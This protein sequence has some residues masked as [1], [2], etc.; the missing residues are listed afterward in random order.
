MALSIPTLCVQSFETLLGKL[1]IT[2]LAETLLPSQIPS[3]KFVFLRH[4]PHATAPESFVD[5]NKRIII[6]CRIENERNFSIIEV[7][8]LRKQEEWKN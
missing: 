8:L 6:N 4:I 7:S 5:K 3:K 2:S 1:E